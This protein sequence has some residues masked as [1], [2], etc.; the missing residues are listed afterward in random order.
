MVE[1]ADQRLRGRHVQESQKRWVRSHISFPTHPPLSLYSLTLRVCGVTP[2]QKCRRRTHAGGELIKNGC[3]R[4]VIFDT[5]LAS[6]YRTPMNFWNDLLWQISGV[7]LFI[8]DSELEELHFQLPRRHRTEELAKLAKTTKFTRKEIQLIYR[9]FKQVS[10]SLPLS[11]P[12]AWV[13]CVMGT[14]K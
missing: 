5:F 3:T 10:W 6:G 8:V 11:H 4:S 7:F 13:Y 9:G 1:S 2:G 12:R 14:R